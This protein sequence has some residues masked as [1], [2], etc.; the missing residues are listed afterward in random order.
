[1]RQT[2]HQN[3]TEYA[4]VETNVEDHEWVLETGLLE[5]A[6]VSRLMRGKEWRL[7]KRSWFRQTL[8]GILEGEVCAFRK[9]ATCSPGKETGV[10]T[11][12]SNVFYAV[13]EGR[14]KAKC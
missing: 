7:R 14:S 8:K 1:M 2:S 4:F 10:F 5:T 13:Q 9:A 6:H 12:K 11:D 3:G